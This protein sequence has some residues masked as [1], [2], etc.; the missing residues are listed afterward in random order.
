MRGG[1]S[2]CWRLETHP[3]GPSIRAVEGL[4]AVLQGAGD[5]LELAVL[6]PHLLLREPIEGVPLAGVRPYE[7]PR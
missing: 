3:P 1:C 4:A 5:A 2:T 7:A 6:G